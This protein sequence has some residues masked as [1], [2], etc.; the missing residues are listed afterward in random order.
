MARKLIEFKVHSSQDKYDGR[1]R[2]KHLYAMVDN[3]KFYGE[4]QLW[5]TIKEGGDSGKTMF[6]CKLEEWAKVVGLFDEAVV[7]IA[8]KSLAEMF[9]PKS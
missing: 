6:T 4:S 1:V 3:V 9:D 7:E 5:M 2:T 8:G